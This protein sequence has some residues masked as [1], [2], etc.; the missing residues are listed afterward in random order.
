M[1]HFRVITIIWKW[2]YVE[3]LEI[4]DVEGDKYAKVVCINQMMTPAQVLSAIRDEVIRRYGIESQ[5]VILFHNKKGVFEEDQHTEIREPL[6]DEYAATKI[7]IG[8]FSEGMNF[9]YYKFPPIDMGLISDSGTFG[10]FIQHLPYP[11]ESLKF[12]VCNPTTGDIFLKY[13]DPVWTFYAY[14]LK[15]HLFV[16][17]EQLFVHFLGLMDIANYSE[18]LPYYLAKEEI[19][20]LNLNR[21]YRVTFGISPS[22]IARAFPNSQEIE[23][24]YKDLKS[25]LEKTPLN[26]PE[27]LKS[28]A[29]KFRAVLNLIPGEIY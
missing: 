10:P 24:V 25:H 14:Q 18:P 1:P 8:V 4:R 23:N 11:A 21:T 26:T 9:V 27:Y 20:R 22:E 7:H 16:L 12:H 17:K 5:Y 6:I 13:F 2:L 19:F 29:E 15:Y 3:T 28:V